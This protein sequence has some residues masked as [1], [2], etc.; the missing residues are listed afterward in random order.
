MRTI[1]DI[2]VLRGISEAAKMERNIQNR[3]QVLEAMSEAAKNGNRYV[4]LSEGRFNNDL[5]NE[6]QS[7]G[8][9]LTFANIIIIEW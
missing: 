4:E 8:Y 9:Q 2:N 6:L 7:A 5:K 1:P 3:N